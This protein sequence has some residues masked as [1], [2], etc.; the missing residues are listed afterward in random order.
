MYRDD[1]S[2]SR[3]DHLLQ[4]GTTWIWLVEVKESTST[5]VGVVE[6]V[7]RRINTTNQPT[8]ERVNALFKSYYTD[9]VF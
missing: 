9:G 4:G 3:K 5:F 7:L 8:G 1:N 6:Y 2:A